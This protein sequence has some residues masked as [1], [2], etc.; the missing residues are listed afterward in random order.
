MTDSTAD[1]KSL[2]EMTSTITAAYLAN[3]QLAP[4]HV[5]KLLHD[6]HGALKHAVDG[7]GQAEAPEPAV[8]PRKAVQKDK[9]YCL[10]CG[11]GFKAIKRHLKTAHDLDPQSYRQRWG[12][13]A[14]FPMVAPN[15]AAKRSQVAK[16][17]GLGRSRGTSS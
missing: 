15:Y 14:D 2:T 6:I 12:L 3:N 4:D 7:G 16:E 8:S 5:S 1:N 11:K 10:E 9:V 13:S 17:I